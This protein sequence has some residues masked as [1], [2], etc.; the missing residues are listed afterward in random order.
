[1]TSTQKGRL[2]RPSAVSGV[3]LRMATFAA[4][5]AIAIV[6]MIIGGSTFHDLSR[7]AFFLERAAHSHEQLALV[8]RLEADVNLLLLDL[9]ARGN[10][11]EWM[12]L[13]D[14]GARDVERALALHLANIAQEKHPFDAE[15]AGALPDGELA[16]AL[17]LRDM[18]RA[19]QQDLGLLGAQ[20]NAYPALR[21]SRGMAGQR[22]AARIA[23]LRMKG[24]KIVEAERRELSAT[25][26]AMATLRKR[27]VAQAKLVGILLVAGGLALFQVLR[28]GL[29]APL[30]A[31]SQ[32][33]Q[34]SGAGQT[35]IRGTPGGLREL[36]ALG[37][38]F[39][40]M[41]ARLAFQQA[42]LQQANA[43]LDTTVR[44]RT[45]ALEAKTEQ[46][47]AIDRSRRLFFAKIGHE[48]RTPITV[49]CGEAELALR[50]KQA[51]AGALRDSLRHILANCTAMERRLEDL[52]ALA[53]SEEGRIAIRRAPIDLA[54]CLCS[55]VELATAFALSRNVSLEVQGAGSPAPVTG[56]ESWLRQALL[57]LIDNAVKFSPDAGR[58]TLRLEQR[59]EDWA[60]M[61]MD[62]GPGAP[63]ASLCE[64][65]NPYFQGDEGAR[66]GGSGLGLAVVRWIADQH[67]GSISASNRPEGGLCV[68]LRLPG[69]PA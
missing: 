17:A 42:E 22:V 4:V 39:N 46:L 12:S 26:A 27:F 62:E 2:G 34:L 7:A 55:A 69:L 47:A 16:D 54:R 43:R 10:Q 68:A 8:T 15:D 58:I 35:L 57:A 13:S 67:S 36:R 37:I 65:F 38:Q 59:G 40:L 56:D 30:A 49:L 32:T 14:V 23:Q 9:S 19:L 25:N 33:T 18:F 29:L 1:M 5:A 52:L 41:A 28:R 31:L 61:V 50:Q 11:L 63:E 21:D 3:S 44:E 51:D 24:A 6:V 45:R 20:P 64:L 48:L 66:R 60:L 53:Q